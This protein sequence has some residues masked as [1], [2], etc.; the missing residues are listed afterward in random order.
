MKMIKLFFSLDRKMK[1]LLFEAYLSLAWARILKLL[2]FSKVAPSLGE[3][4]AETSFNKNSSSRE[5]LAHISQ[6]LQMVSPYTF[7]ES[8]C[9]VRAIAAMKMLARR[10]I[11]STLYLGTAKDE[12]GEFIA[13]AWLRSGPLY[14]TGMDGMEKYTIVQKFAKVSR[15][16]SEGESSN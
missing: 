7:F 10:R 4:M 16:K 11:D 5:V 13:H 14:I 15:G 9:L 3:Q 8:E 2:P 1:L 6:A 12:T